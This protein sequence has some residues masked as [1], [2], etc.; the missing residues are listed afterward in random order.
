MVPGGLGALLGEQVD[1]MC[2]IRV[3]VLPLEMA[4]SPTALGWAPTS[5]KLASFIAYDSL[6]GKSNSSF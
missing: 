5:D 6:V 3:E 1:L 4:L 2:I